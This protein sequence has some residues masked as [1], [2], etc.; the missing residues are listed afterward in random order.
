[1]QIVKGD[2]NGYPV[3]LEVE[4]DQPALGVINTVYRPTRMGVGWQYDILSP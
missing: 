1:M 2:R 4:L 3:Y